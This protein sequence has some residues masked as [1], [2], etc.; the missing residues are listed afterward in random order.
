MKLSKEEQEMV[1]KLR[2]E[3]E[4]EKPVKSGVLKHNLYRVNEQRFTIDGWLFSEEEKAKII[5]RFDD[6]FT[7]IPKGTEMVCYIEDGEESWYDDDSLNGLSADWAD[8]NVTD[9]KKLRKKA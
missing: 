8:E 6:R 1:L 3:K 5:N 4:A 9:I 7:L 2:A